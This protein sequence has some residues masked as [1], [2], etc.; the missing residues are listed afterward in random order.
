MT[1]T[2]KMLLYTLIYYSQLALHV[3]GDVFVHH[4]EHLTVFTASGSLQ[5]CH[6]R[7]ACVYRSIQET[8]VTTQLLLV[9]IYKLM[10][11]FG[12]FV[13]PS[14]GHKVYVVENQ[15]HT[16]DCIIYVVQLPLTTY[17]LRPED[18]LTN[19]PKYVI[20]LKINTKSS[21]VV[22]YLFPN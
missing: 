7:C 8:N 6:P 22:T 16:S 18:G 13:R 15:C 3:S 4:Q 17:I 1:A 10:T 20:N 19:R 21:C 12:L 14:S 2:H 5:M 9:F 11:C